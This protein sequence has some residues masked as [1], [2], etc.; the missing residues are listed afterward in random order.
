MNN[1][2]RLQLSSAPVF[3]LIHTVEGIIVDAEYTDESWHLCCCCCNKKVRIKIVEILEQLNT[4]CY[5]D[6]TGDTVHSLHD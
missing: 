3:I 4:V 5:R 1:E 2:W 6:K